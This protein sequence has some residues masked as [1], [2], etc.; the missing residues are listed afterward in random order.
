MTREVVSV[1]VDADEAGDDVMGV[2]Q[3]ADFG[4][5]DFAFFGEVD[6]L[7]QESV[8]QDQGA[9]LFVAFDLFLFW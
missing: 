1:F 3:L 6:V 9:L 2:S 4:F 5:H 8:L 7:L